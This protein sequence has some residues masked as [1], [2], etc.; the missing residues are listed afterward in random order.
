MMSSHIEILQEGHLEQLHHVFAYP[1]KHH[2]Y[3]IALNPSDQAIDQSEFERQ[4]WTSSEFSHVAGKE[5]LT[6]KIPSPI[7]F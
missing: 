5:D 7:G 3:Y 6:Q 1:K 4:D 2:N